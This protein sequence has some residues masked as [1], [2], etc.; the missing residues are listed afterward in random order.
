VNNLFHPDHY[1]QQHITE[2]TQIQKYINF[3]H[4]IQFLGLS[5]VT[6]NSKQQPK[7]VPKI[8]KFKNKS[9]SKFIRGNREN[10]SQAKKF[11]N[12]EIKIVHLPHKF[13]FGNA[14]N[15]A[16]LFWET[17]LSLDLSLS[18]SI[19]EQKEALTNSERE[20]NR[21]MCGGRKRESNR[22]LDL[23]LSLSIRLW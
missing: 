20:S 2:Q 9:K 17:D 7:N 5:F 18:I 15:Q 14:R 8:Q 23:D 10:R 16:K 19:T 4:K 3:N 1:L 13:N 21:D 22:D 11:G 12:Q 6:L